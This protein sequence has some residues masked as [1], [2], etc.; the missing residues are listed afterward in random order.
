MNRDAYDQLVAQAS[1]EAI[2]RLLPNGG[3]G[4]VTEHQLRSALDVFAQRVASHTRS[5]ELLN[6]ATADE[7]AER[8]SISKRRVQAIIAHR[9]ERWGYGRKI[10]N[11]W[12]VSAAEIPLIE[13]DIKHR[14]KN[15][16]E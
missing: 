5:Y 10:G 7:L 14:R 11:T 15:Q 6:I 13:P 1:E 4:R 16:T 9:H 2:D 12:V 8:W 3:G